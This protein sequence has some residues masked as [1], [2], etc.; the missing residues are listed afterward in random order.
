MI[1]KTALA[2][3]LIAAGAARATAAPQE[4]QLPSGTAVVFVS[5]GRLG[6]DAKVGSVTTVHLLA[7]VTLDGSVVIPAGTRARLI[8]GGHPLVNG[9]RSGTI[10]SLDSFA[11]RYG[12]LPIHA[13]AT[14]PVIDVGATIPAATDAP[15]IAQNGTYSIAIPFPFSLSNDQP[16]AAYTPTPARTP[17]GAP[18]P[19]PRRGRGGSSPRPSAS[20]S[21]TPSAIPTPTATP[22]PIAPEDVLPTPTVTIP[23]SAIIAP[24]GP[25][26]TD[27]PFPFPVTPRPTG[28]PS[29]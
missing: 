12:T 3:V 16:A 26:P 8:V 11:T 27:T 10:V 18:S 14:V 25:R 28:T 15:I 2:A 7:D 17:G 20:P 9:V 21:A 23:P 24:K 6:L 5:D 29:S 1:R 19:I 4:H 22:S 13:T